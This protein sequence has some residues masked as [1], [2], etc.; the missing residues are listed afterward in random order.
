[1]EI[2]FNTQITVD[3]ALS[4]TSE[5]PVQNKV[6]TQAI[7]DNKVT[8]DSALSTNSVN[9]VQNK[10]V[11]QAINDN[12]VTVDSALSM[13]SVNPV[14]N[15]VI[16]EAL[17]TVAPKNIIFWLSEDNTGGNIATDQPVFVTYFEGGQFKGA[18]ST[19]TK[20]NYNVE[21]VS[22]ANSYV[23]ISNNNGFTSLTLS[24]FSIDKFDI[25][26]PVSCSSIDLSGNKL[27]SFDFALLNPE[28]IKEIDLSS[29]ELSQLDASYVSNFLSIDLLNVSN[30]QFLSDETAATAFANSL[31]KVTNH[32]ILILSNLDT[33]TETVKNIANNKG[34]RIAIKEENTI[35]G[36]GDNNDFFIRDAFKDIYVNYILYGET[37]TINIP[38]F[39]TPRVECD[40]NTNLILL[41]NTNLTQLVFSFKF[42]FIK[43][44]PSSMNTLNIAGCNLDSF[45]AS[46]LPESIGTVFCSG[47]PFLSDE[48][49]S[50]AFANSLP[51]VESGILFIGSGATQYEL[52]KSIASAKGWIVYNS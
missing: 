16:Y 48:A 17:Q 38:S 33:Y 41:N 36:I 25:S 46:I 28:S 7:N 23:S 40:K 50:T 30:N 14:Q 18:A 42:S 22:D 27:K 12:K 10:V 29:N 44:L 26:S 20:G 2:K 52:I 43:Y 11:T 21:I 8:V 3:S 5:N 34:W 49:A 45:D 13:T 24:G 6:V 1:M 15:K 4:T 35:V 31:P 39:N 32:A 19:G 9:P 37:Q 47:N 51:T